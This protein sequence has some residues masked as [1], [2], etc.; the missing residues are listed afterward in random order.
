MPNDTAGRATDAIQTIGAAISIYNAVEIYVCAFGTFKRYNTLYCWS[1]L[2]C[3]SGLLMQSISWTL[4]SYN[5]CVGNDLLI[6]LATSSLGW[7]AMV[8]GFSVTLYSRLTIIDVPHVYCARIK[9]LIIFNF[10]FCHLLTTMFTYGSRL[11]GSAFWVTGYSIIE[12]IQVTMFLI[13]EVILSSMYIIHVGTG[14]GD[15]MRAVQKATLYVNILVLILDLVVVVVEYLD[16][17]TIQVALKLAIYSIKIKLEFLILRQLTDASDS[18]RKS[19]AVAAKCTCH[20]TEAPVKSL[21][22][23]GMKS[24]AL[25][26]ALSS[27]SAVVS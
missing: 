19:T 6:A 16:L 21:K 11:I 8:T 1:V 17:F 23:I 14:Y 5:C 7:W 25:P 24:N 12:K 4:V 18:F 20:Q 9:M 27:A 13:Q 2:T 10:V 22:A 3:A 26:E 15:E